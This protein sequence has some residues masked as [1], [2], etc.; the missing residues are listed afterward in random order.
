MAINIK[1]CTWFVEKSN[2]IYRKTYAGWW[3][4]WRADERAHGSQRESLLPCQVVGKRDPPES[5]WA[6]N[7]AVCLLNM[8]QILNYSSIKKKKIPAPLGSLRCSC[9]GAIQMEVTLKMFCRG[10]QQERCFL[11]AGLAD[12]IGNH[13][14]FVQVYVQFLIPRLP[15][16]DG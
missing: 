8:S 14:F 11:E 7:L 15:Q 12:S 4:H 13:S 10:T 6:R 2:R 16:C 9:F 3:K 1:N 5:S